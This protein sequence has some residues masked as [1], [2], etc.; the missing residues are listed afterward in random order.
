MSP[1][2]TRKPEKLGVLS[3]SPRNMGDFVQAI[4]TFPAHCAF[5][6]QT[7]APAMSV[8]LHWTDDGLPLGMMFGSAY[9]NE[10]LLFRLAA[11]LETA[12]PWFQRRPPV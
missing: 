9:G 11:Q 6:N 4:S 5:Y 3:L 7:G 10:G 8:P 12:R 2:I 1:T